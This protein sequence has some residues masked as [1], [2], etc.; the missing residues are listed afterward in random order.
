MEMEVEETVVTEVRLGGDGGTGR[1]RRG[2]GGGGGEITYD[3]LFVVLL[4][5]S[6]DFLGYSIINVWLSKPAGYVIS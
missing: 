4:S 1:G 6:P 2:R 3:T 5:W